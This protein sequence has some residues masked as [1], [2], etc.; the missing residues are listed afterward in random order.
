MVTPIN[1]MASFVSANDLAK[2][3][4]KRKEDRR[5]ARKAILEDAKDSFLKEKKR[6]ELKVLFN[7]CNY[8]IFVGMSLIIFVFIP[9]ICNIAPQICNIA[10]QICNI[11]PQICNIAPQTKSLSS[12]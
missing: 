5:N 10:P 3:R 1:K 4:E 12:T 2:E 8:S 9:Q 11:A 6:R 7:D